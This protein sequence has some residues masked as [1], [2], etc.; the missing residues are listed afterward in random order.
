MRFVALFLVATIGLLSSVGT[1]QADGA[2]VQTGSVTFPLPP[3]LPPCLSFPEVAPGLQVCGIGGSVDYHLVF[4]PQGNENSQ[5]D[6]H[7][8]TGSVLL[9]GLPLFVFTTPVDAHIVLHLGDQPSK[10]LI[11]VNQGPPGVPHK[12]P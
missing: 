6:V 8:F 4:T 3:P 11:L 2:L 5:F 7:G 12:L 1:A 10:P 9:G